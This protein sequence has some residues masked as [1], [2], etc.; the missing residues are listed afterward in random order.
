MRQHVNPLSEKYQQPIDLPDWGNIYYQLYLPLHLD[1]GCGKGKFLLD[2]APLYP[3]WN[4]LGLEIKEKLVDNANEYKQELG[5]KNLHYLFCNA[6]TSLNSILAS[7]PEKSLHYVSIQFPDPWFK[8]RH[9]KR[10]VVQS[11]LVTDLAKYLVNDGTVFIQSDILP[12]AE[13]MCTLFSENSDFERSQSHWLQTNP[14]SIS[15]EREKSTINR[16][17]PVYRALFR[18]IKR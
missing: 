10:R 12:V 1:I 15:T 16:E 13:E 6:N 9:Y 8:K 18:R 14:L 17:Q 11:E 7:L 3:N 4:F 5:L 2:M